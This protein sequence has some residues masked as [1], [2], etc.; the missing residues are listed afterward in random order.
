MATKLTTL[1]SHQKSNQIKKVHCP[2]PLILMFYA[3]FAI[4]CYDKK[5]AKRTIKALLYMSKQENEFKN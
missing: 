3:I 5:I 2:T 4:W 1:E